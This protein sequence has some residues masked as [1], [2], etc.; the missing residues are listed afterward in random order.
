M[1]KTPV[2][3]VILA[4]G[5]SSR[6]FPFN[7]I[8]SD[9]TGSGRSLI[10]QSYDRLNLIPKKQIFV[11]TV[12]EMVAPIQK[13]LKLPA[14]HIFVDPVRRGTWPALL[15]AMAHLRRENPDVVMGVVTG[16]H[17]IPKVKEFQKAFRQSV[18]TAA[19]CAAFVVIPVTPN[20]HPEDWNRF[21]EPL[22]AS[23]LAKSSVL[24]KSLLWIAR[25]R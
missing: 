9:L 4:G 3:A 8:L 7:K 15:W 21:L 18:E 14:K 22:R 24:K 12:R 5:Q 16:D 20:T 25:A 13:Q 23:R 2:Y 10:Q 11:L 17:V 19:D 1:S 6:L